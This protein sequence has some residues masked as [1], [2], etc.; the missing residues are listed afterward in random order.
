MCQS[1]AYQLANNKLPSSALANNMWIGEVP[2]ELGMLTLPERLLVARYYPA[3]YIIKLF[4][5]Q[6]GSIHW[7]SSN[8]NS[9]LQGNVS[10]YCMNTQDIASMVEGQLLPPN[11][12]FLSATIG[13]T[14]VGPNNI[15]DRSLPSLLTV[16][17]HHVR[18][19]LLFLQRENPL[20]RD[21][22]I[23][24]ENL[25]LLPEFG[26][27]EEIKAIVRHS[28]DLDLLEQERAGYIDDDE[29]KEKVS[30]FFLIFNVGT[31]HWFLV[32]PATF[33]VQAFGVLDP[34][35][36]DVDDQQILAQALANTSFSRAESYAVRQGS[37]FVTEYARRDENDLLTIGQPNNPNHLLGAFPWLFPYACGGFEVEHPISVSY[38]AHAA[39]A[40]RFADRRFRLDLQFMFQLFGVIQ[41]RQVCR[42]AVIQVK[43]SEF[44]KNEEAFCH[45]QPSDLKLASTEE[46]QHR[47]HSNPT[48]Q[49]LMKHIS[50]V[51]SKVMGTD[52]S[53]RSIRSYIWGMTIRKS[54]PSLWITINPT[55]THNPIAQVFTGADIDLD[56]FDK[57]AGPDSS[58][59]S[60]R[61]AKDP[62]AAAKF[63][64]FTINVLL[65]T[66][67][68]ICSERSTSVLRCKCGVF[69]IVEGYIGTVE[70]QGRGTLHL[71]MMVWLR[72]APTAE[73]M[74]ELLSTDCFR[75]RIA[76]YIAIN[77]R[78]HHPELDE[79]ALSIVP[80][81]SAVSYSRPV[82]P[83]SNC[84]DGD[85]NEAEKKLVRAVQIHKCGP[86]CMVVV[87]GRLLCKRH[88]PF[89]LAESAWV[90]ALGNWGPQRQVGMMNNWVPTLLHATRSNHDCKLIT[91]GEET[92]DISFYFTNY[93]TK[94][95]QHSSN[96][97]A[98]L[99][100]TLAFHQAT[101]R[102]TDDYHTLN[103]RLIQ[104]CAN[105]LSREQ[106]F[107]A[108]E[109]VSYLMNWGDRYI[110]H[111]FEPIYFS[112]VISHLQQ[113]YPSLLLSQKIEG[114]DKTREIQK[115]EVH[116]M[117]EY[118]DCGDALENYSY[119]DF[120]VNTYD[121]FMPAEETNKLPL[122]KHNVRIPYRANRGHSARCRVLRS[123][124][125]ETMPYFPGQW[126]PH[127]N[128]VEKHELY[129]A[130]ILTLLK[131]WRS[132]ATLKCQDLSFDA[133]FHNF[134]A[135][136]P[137]SFSRTIDNIQY[138]Y[139]CADKAQERRT[140]AE[141]S[142]AW[143]VASQ[144]PDENVDE[145]N[146]LNE[147][148]VAMVEKVIED[149]IQDA[150]QSKMS[151]RERLYA[152]VAIGIA[153]DLG[154]FDS[155]SKDTPFTHPASE[156]MQC[157][158][159]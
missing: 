117:R 32:E 91:N 23:S 72:G 35:A 144:V 25:A 55:D 142:T 101:E 65:D 122:R 95:Q 36:S 9:G 60:L 17:R 105:T 134:I 159:P 27:P 103:K 18:N 99:A 141:I 57:T 39:W 88:A 68:G 114:Q 139:N 62:Y 97:S 73:R 148:S 116:Q 33:P 79:E 67:F 150:M 30:V 26:V 14:I 109:V 59:R 104:R 132:L 111:H 53:R 44:C 10:T 129:C 4:P 86:G 123:D 3:A 80:R 77:I 149:D 82:N 90:D 49:A 156:P 8:L 1:C 87:K 140:N 69:G 130:S 50:A 12:T 78:E 19:A 146:G 138:H 112:S 152:D 6:K 155:P 31:Y 20:Y 84:Y 15:P 63:F 11:P 76:T 37:T 106:E 54:P 22:V 56:R 113:C 137:P 135:E 147:I 153:E 145:D 110:S 136:S 75:K 98:L 108:P 89:P 38:E 126:F 48:V 131:P 24:E 94:N 158:G 107:S 47:K 143:A 124:G 5:K 70:A 133:A 45:L 52:E 118:M 64:H 74:K 96:S 81:E 61:I 100:R 58:T 93:S 154:F 151:S 128:D 41:K 157:F 7:D 115:Y 83:W 42:S 29:E 28:D 92:T 102:R 16:S 119:L 120:F 13:V 66:I 127:A 71:H 21:I 43:K 85:R 34:G 46:D 51:R 125:H 2:E 121:A 40:M